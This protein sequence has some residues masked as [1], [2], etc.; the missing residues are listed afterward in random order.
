MPRSAKL[1][2]KLRGAGIPAV[3]S[4]AGPTVLALTRG[5]DG[6][7]AASLAGATWTVLHLGVDRDGAR[8]VPVDS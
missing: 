2:D 6:M 4:G 1:V 3:I 7:A 8:S 5:D